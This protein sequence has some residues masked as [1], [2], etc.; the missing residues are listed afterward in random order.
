MVRGLTFALVLFAACHRPEAPI[1]QGPPEPPLPTLTLDEAQAQLGRPG[2]YVFDANP[3][4]MFDRGHLPG[5]KWVD[6]DKV[7]AS[8]L[9]PERQATLIF[10][11][12]NEWCTASHESARLAAGFGYSHVFLMPR[13]ILGWKK[14]GKP[15]ETTR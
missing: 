13:G 4:E 7:M 2:V 15:I 1:R 12:A 5:A 10:Y 6:W 8:D 11:C 9:P 14:D 3:R